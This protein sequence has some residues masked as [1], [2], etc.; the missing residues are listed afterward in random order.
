MSKQ[1]SYD[2]PVP[3]QPASLDADEEALWRAL[4]RVIV[5]LPRLLDDDLRRTGLSLSEYAVLMNLSEAPTRELRMS[6]LAAA[7]ELSASRITRVIDDLQQRGFVSKRRATEDGRGNVAA[8]TS[9]GLD[10]LA[11]AYP[12]HLGSA[13]R[14]VMDHLDPAVTGELA[15]QLASVAERLGKR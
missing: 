7:T 10:A 5:T 1:A 12:D 8:L 4:L 6:D 14:H 11:K 3:Q 9:D 2:Q 13:R 15:R